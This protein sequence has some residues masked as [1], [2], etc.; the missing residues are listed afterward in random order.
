MLRRCLCWC[1][2]AKPAVF[3]RRLYS[4]HRTPSCVVLRHAFESH[5]ARLRFGQRP[6][7]ARIDRVRALLDVFERAT[8]VWTPEKQP[9]T[10]LPYLWIPRLRRLK[11]RA[12]AGRS[13]A[14]QIRW[15]RRT[16]SALCPA[17]T[18]QI[19]RL[20]MRCGC[21]RASTQF[22]R[23]SD[24]G[25]STSSSSLER[26]SWTGRPRPSSRSRAVGTYPV[27]HELSV[28]LGR[29]ARRPSN[30]RRSAVRHQ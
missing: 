26:T 22:R 23:M 3:V 2:S 24:A 20:L 10:R 5:D 11:L 25:G 28:R 18:T 7:A 27:V 1:Y 13:L 29:D 14:N 9:F 30:A 12:P 19:R 6:A 17:Y 8:A 15:R 16:A 21:C 4:R